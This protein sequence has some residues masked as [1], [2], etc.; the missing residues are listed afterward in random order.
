MIGPRQYGPLGLSSLKA[1]ALLFALFFT[2]AAASATCPSVHASGGGGHSWYELDVDSSCLSNNGG[3]STTIL[4]CPASGY[5]ADA[6]GSSASWSFVVPSGYTWYSNWSV[7]AF[8]DFDSPTHTIYDSLYAT[9]SVIHN[10]TSTNYSLFHLQGN[11]A[12]SQSC[13][14]YDKSITATTG[15]T[16]TI[17]YSGSS[18]ADGG[19]MKATVPVVFSSN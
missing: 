11:S 15:D 5:S 14:R 16:I 9:V 8:V 7:T 6:F 13:A 12:T 10:G 3:F 18:A 19:T 2:A 1:L 4:S 17:S